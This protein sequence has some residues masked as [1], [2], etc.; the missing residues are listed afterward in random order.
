MTH[1]KE[2]KPL[3]N[4][5]NLVKQTPV[6]ADSSIRKK[7][8]PIY[9]SPITKNILSNSARTRI[10][11][12]LGKMVAV[13]TVTEEAP[14]YEGF[15][16]VLAA[17]AAMR[18]LSCEQIGE[19]VGNWLVKMPNEDPSKQTI[20]I[21]VHAD[22]VPV[23]ERKDWK[24]EPFE[25]VVEGDKAY[26]RG[27]ADCKSG[28]AAGLEAM[29]RLL[30]DGNSNVNVQML[31][32]RDE[33]NGSAL[34]FKYLA[35]SGLLKADAALVLDTRPVITFASSGVIGAK[36][37]FYGNTSDALGIFDSIMEY[38]GE[39]AKVESVCL[40]TEAP[41]PN[42]WGRV[43]PTIINFHIKAANSGISATAIW[44]GEKTNSVP[45]T[46]YVDFIIPRSFVSLM[47]G[48]A[49]LVTAEQ[50][51]HDF[52]KMLRGKLSPD[53]ELVAKNDAVQ[54]DS[55]GPSGQI[56]IRGKGGHAGYTHQTLNPIPEAIRLVREYIRGETASMAVLGVDAR[57]LPE[58]DILKIKGELI[59]AFQKGAGDGLNSLKL[60]D[61]KWSMHAPCML[62]KNP[63]NDAL[64][65]QVQAAFAGQGLETGIYGGLGGLD[66][67]M[68]IKVGI[69][70]LAA[71]PQNASIHGPNEYVSLP[72]IQKFANLTVELSKNWE[73]LPGKGIA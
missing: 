21:A 33:E 2:T 4:D 66:L 10:I 64:V 36:T 17:E 48:P 55:E 39:R 20:L 71:G 29:H 6:P 60:N 16:K 47:G 49:S 38:A 59:E 13:R 56:E 34:G 22:V 27:A 70:S 73:N 15:G 9:E 1:R 23:G 26:G 11:E 54:L 31:V 51:W 28:I 43:T 44:G 52:V 67:D 37:E 19:H 5:F 50:G 62:E 35:N 65:R 45:G 41:R 69:P 14:D 46:C 40:A 12:S 3:N 68:L 57:A 72:Q 58:E 61:D 63:T 7:A 32:G 25:F 42:V 18:N 30:Q 24:T 53:F 8:V